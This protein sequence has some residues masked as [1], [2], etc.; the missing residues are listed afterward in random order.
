MVFLLYNM[1]M[2]A[3]KAE[4]LQELKRKEIIC[5]ILSIKLKI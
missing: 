4:I 5:Y 2:S 3:I 1:I